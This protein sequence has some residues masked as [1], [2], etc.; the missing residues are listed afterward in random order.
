MKYVCTACG[1]I[2]DPKEGDVDNGIEAGT[3]FDQLPEDWVCPVCGAG[4]DMFEPQE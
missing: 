4:K 1:Y 2:Y 3:E